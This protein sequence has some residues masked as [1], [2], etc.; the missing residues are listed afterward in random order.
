MSDLHQCP[1]CPCDY[2]YEDRDAIVCPE[3]GYQWSATSQAGDDGIA[4]P[5]DENGLIVKDANGSLLADG[6]TV[7]IIKDLK[8]KGA[9]S[10]IKV[11][12]KVKNI[13]L[14]TGDH[15]LDCKVPGIGAMGLKSE[16]VRKVE[17]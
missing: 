4:T 5:A 3:C 11:G 17:G 13:R 12:T 10:V 9:G 14:T 6:D 15:N 16:F 8:V 2:A 7:T 1:N